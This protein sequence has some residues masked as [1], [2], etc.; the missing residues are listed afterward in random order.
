MKTIRQ[1][2]LRYIG[3]VRKAGGFHG[4]VMLAIEDGTAE[5]YAHEKFFFILLEGKPVPFAIQSIEQ[6]H[7][8]HIVKFEDVNTVEEAKKLVNKK[9]FVEGDELPEQDE[10]MQWSDLVGYKVM[11]TDAG[12]LGMITEVVEYPQQW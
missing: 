6:R 8:D 12:D 5:D 10:E 3:F 4:G 11:D 7:G 9:V 2:N 1:E